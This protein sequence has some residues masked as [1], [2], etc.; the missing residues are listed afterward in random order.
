MNEKASSANIVLVYCTSLFVGVLSKV[1]PSSLSE[2]VE[3]RRLAKTRCSF[4]GGGVA[5]PVIVL[6]KVPSS[7]SEEVERREAR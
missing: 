4:G 2:E 6:Q 1:I 5:I 7:L 3:K